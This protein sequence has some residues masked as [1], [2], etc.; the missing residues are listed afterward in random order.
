M[1]DEEVSETSFRVA[2]EGFYTNREDVPQVERD[3]YGNTRI[4][5][6]GLPLKYNFSGCSKS[7]ASEKK[8]VLTDSS[9]VSEEDEE[10]EVN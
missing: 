4:T 3:T 8:L 2:S 9:Y 10:S 6:F 7:N 5:L 1:Y